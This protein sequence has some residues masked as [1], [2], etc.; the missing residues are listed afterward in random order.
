MKML[1]VL[2]HVDSELSLLSSVRLVSS[3]WPLIEVNVEKHVKVIPSLH[4]SEK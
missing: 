3:N 4:D 2:A 1:K